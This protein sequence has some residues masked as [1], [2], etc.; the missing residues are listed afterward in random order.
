MAGDDKFAILEYLDEIEDKIDKAIP[1]FEDVIS[2]VKGEDSDVPG[3]Q[4]EKGERGERGDTV[5]G[6]QGPQGDQGEPGRDGRDGRDGED[7]RN[8]RDGKNGIDGA[9]DTGEEIIEKIN[10]TPVGPGLKIDSEH[11]EGFDELKNTVRANAARV[12]SAPVG[13]RAYVGGVKKGLLQEVNF[14]AGSNM[15]ITHSVVNGLPTITFASSGGG[16]SASFI[17]NELLGTGDDNQTVFTLAST[18][19]AGTVCVY[20]GGLRQ[21]LTTDYLISGST[22]TFTFKV[23]TGQAVVADY[24]I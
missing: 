10:K 23:P 17:N 6:P 19:V 22:V 16:G 1:A 14:V 12:N 11:V 2:K 3:P 5:V 7:G 18:P 20:A 15:T 21:T 8:G 4:G 24:Q 13:F 9:P